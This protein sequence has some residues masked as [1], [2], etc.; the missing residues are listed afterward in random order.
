MKPGV[1]SPLCTPAPTTV[2]GFKVSLAS[3]R[4]VARLG[5]VSC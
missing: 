1:R 2:V 3:V 4:V 5:L